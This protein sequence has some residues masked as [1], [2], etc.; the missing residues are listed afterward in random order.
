[1][2]GSNAIPP[3]L[4]PKG[5][6]HRRLDALAGKPNGAFDGHLAAKERALSTKPIVQRAF[7]RTA[8]AL[9]FVIRPG[10]TILQAR[11]LGHALP[12]EIAIVLKGRE[13]TNVNA[14]QIVGLFAR[15]NP[16]GQ[17]VTGAAGVSE[18]VPVKACRHMYVQGH[19]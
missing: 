9:Q 6:I 18:A 8:G 4:P 3:I 16:L 19:R 5:V 17:H 14:P 15:Q 2:F 10:H 1:M 7:A 12:Q 13:A 11:S